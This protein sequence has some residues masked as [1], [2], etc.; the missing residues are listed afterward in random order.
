MTNGYFRLEVR[1]DGTYL[2][3]YPPEPGGS[4]CD[5]NEVLNYLDIYNVAYDKIAIYNLFRNL[6]SQKELRISVTK[7]SAFDET[8][9]FEIGENFSSVTARFYPEVEGGKKLSKDEIIWLLNKRGIKSGIREDVIDQFLHERFYCTSYVIA[10]AQPP[11]EGSD[12][13]IEYFFNTDLTKKPKMNEDGSVDFHQLDNLSKVE[14][15]QVLAV[16]TPAVHGKPGVDVLG[17]PIQPRKVNVLFLKQSK[18]ARLSPD[19]LQ[20]ISNVNGHAVVTDKQVFVSDTYEIPGNVDVATGDVEYNGT[21]KIAGNVNSGYKVH[22]DGDVIVEGIVEGAEIIAGGQIVLKRGI[23]GMSKGI[24]N[25]GANIVAKFIESAEVRAGGFIQTESIMHSKVTAGSEIIV[26][27]KK[28]FITGGVIRAGKYIEAKTAG[29]VMGTTTIIEVGENMNLVEEERELLNEKR[30]LRENI[31]KSEKIL[32][33]ISKKIK[34]REQLP[35]E[36]IL[37]FQQ[38]SVSNKEFKKR[39]EEINARLEELDIMLENSTKGYVLVDDVIY[40]GCKVTISNISTY[41]RAETKHCRL[42]RDG[43][44]IRVT[45]Y[46]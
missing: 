4:L 11:V 17:R 43:A 1:N 6:T 20:L 40:P 12:A 33:F 32:F 21:V 41:I 9:D 3:V 24:L 7:V 37:Q 2:I 30:N 44:D 14:K 10:E 29:S 13:K 5:P 23:Q 34:D 28:G 15:D 39:I 18:N 42:I 16:L 35:K 45:A 22:A 36:K 26:R 19:G 25:A 27:G 38:L 46:K 31:D 8:M